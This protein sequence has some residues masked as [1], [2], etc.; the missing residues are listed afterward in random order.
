MVF[1]EIV[2]DLAHLLIYV[3]GLPIVFIGAAFIVGATLWSFSA[4][5]I[6]MLRGDW[7]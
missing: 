6:F 4:V 3:L 7:F 1:P 5:T 2:N